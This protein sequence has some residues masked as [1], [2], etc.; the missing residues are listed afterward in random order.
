MTG[1]EAALAKAQCESLRRIS[2]DW[3]GVVSSLEA[4]DA[5]KSVKDLT[6]PPSIK[7]AMRT[8]GVALA[9]APE[10]FTTAAGVALVA[11]S[12]AMAGEPAALGSL[13][14]ELSGQMSAISEFYVGGLEV[15]L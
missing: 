10:P 6:H 14:E 2:K 11:G 4:R 9:V 5:A 12:F 13:A 15:P 8:A 7:K 1:H 3:A